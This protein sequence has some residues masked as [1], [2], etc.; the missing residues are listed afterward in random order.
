MKKILAVAVLGLA[1]VAANAA[2]TYKL[3]TVKAY[4]PF[5]PLGTSILVGPIPTGGTAVVDGAGNVSATGIQHSFVNA[6]ATYNY[7]GG[8]WTT[9]VGGT[10]IT[11]TETCTETAGVPCTAPLSGLAQAN[12][13]NTT[14]N[15]GAVSPDCSPNPSSFFPA[16]LNCDNVS[17]V[18][19]AG[20]SLKII[21]QSQFAFALFPSGFIYEF[22]P[23]TDG[24]GVLDPHDNCKLV[25]NPTQLDANADGYGNICDADINNTGTVTSSDFG[26][27]RSVLGQAAGASA[28]AAAS[29]M[30]GSGT[31]TSSDFGL[32]RARLG[33]AVGPSGLACAGT[34]PCP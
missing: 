22:F 26:L 8:T 31:V 1:S 32:L 18:E 5:S 11:H 29:D 13:N 17:I 10:S 15:S 27:M 19:V 16:A 24:D 9:V 4:N 2:G 30:N 34:I 3:D 12:W 25:A 14:D 6:N 20:V 21:E 28:T 7:T 23:D 33:T